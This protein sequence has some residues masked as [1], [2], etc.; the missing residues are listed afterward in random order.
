MDEEMEHAPSKTYQVINH[1]IIGRMDDLEAMRQAV[2]KVLSTER[3]DE[4]IYS[5]SYGVEL[6]DYIGESMDLMMA[7]AER[8]ISEALLMDDRIL[9]VDHF[10]MT[11][12]DATTL[13][14]QFDV[15]TIFG[16]FGKEVE[17]TV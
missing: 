2:D 1:R 13:H 7:E 3:F 16:E 14:I 10:E 8:V 9:A 17:V 6:N 11:V 12:V 4:V 5:Q 15:S